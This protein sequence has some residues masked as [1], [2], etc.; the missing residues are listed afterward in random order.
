MEDQIDA[1]ILG[2]PLEQEKDWTEKCPVCGEKP[3]FSCM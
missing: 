2:I 3:E 1:G